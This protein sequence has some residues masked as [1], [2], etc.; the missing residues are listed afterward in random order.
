MVL[1][2]SLQLLFFFKD[3]FLGNVHTQRGAQTPKLEI[4]GAHLTD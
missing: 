2:L 3:L 1:F 4:K